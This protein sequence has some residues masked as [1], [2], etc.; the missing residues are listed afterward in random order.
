LHRSGKQL[1]V[2]TQAK[3]LVLD[4]QREFSDIQGLSN[5]VSRL[6]SKLEQSPYVGIVVATR[7]PPENVP[8]YALQPL[9][10]NDIEELCRLNKWQVKQ[11][12]L[13][14]LHSKSAGNPLLV[15]LFHACYVTSGKLPGS[16]NMGEV[17]QEFLIH[18]N[19]IAQKLLKIV[20]LALS[21]PFEKEEKMIDK[22]DLLAIIPEDERA[23]CEKALE[24]LGKIG[25][26]HI[27]PHL[28]MHD[29]IRGQ[30]EKL[31]PE[32]ELKQQ[33]YALA[34]TLKDSDPLGA[35]WHL[36]KSEN[37]NEAMEL[38]A[39]AVKFSREQMQI[40]RF[41]QTFRAVGHWFE[42]L[43]K[44]EVQEDSKAKYLFSM[45]YIFDVIGDVSN[46]V[47]DCKKAIT[48]FQEAIKV[49]TLERFP[50]QYA[51]IQNNLGNA[52][53]MLAEVDAKPEN[54]KKAIIAFEE[55]LKVHT[56]D[57]FPRDY[58]A[59]QNNLGAAYGTLADVEEKAKNCK[60]AII[61]CEEALK[62]YTR[63]RFPM[64]YAMTQNNLGNA[65]GML[66]AE[67][68]KPENC[69]RAIK[70][71]EEAL[72]VRTLERFPMD[73]ASTQNNLGNAYRTLAEAEE[74]AKNCKKAITA[75]EEAL[76]VRTLERFPMYYADTQ[77]NLGNAYRT[78]AEAE[79]KEENCKKAITAYEEALKVYTKEEFPE[80]HKLVE[81][82][83]GIL[84]AFYKGE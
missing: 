33:H 65:Y 74:R 58:A 76:K 23:Q 36:M 54:C 77:N 47:E 72:K 53:R 55:A 60:K 70:A 35:L 56:L 68:A 8:S 43:S 82:N 42:E 5:L 25:V 28:W 31:L 34:Q 51:M 45:G 2:N 78:L 18:L 64:D 63:E 50:A 61:A 32:S 49:K 13:E 22:D 38:L 16:Q 75:Y 9:N 44:S 66:A 62:V 67:E 15:I 10:L 52:Y 48:A 40:L 30:I 59:A 57:R 69:K 26:V 14:E 20:A 6:L 71:Y 80:V 37:V 83:L 79:E 7:N 17:M 4:S 21:A 3:I 27:N 39:V 1:S 24:E 73:Y 29:E 46:K 84:R 12:I 11:D 41:I 19:P 81:H